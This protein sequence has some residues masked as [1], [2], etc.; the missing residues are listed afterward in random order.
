MHKC[1]NCGE[2]TIS[3]LSKLMLGPGRTIQCKSCNSRVSVSWW[4]SVIFIIFL[5]GIYSMKS[6]L[7]IQLTMVLGT[8]LMVLYLLIHLFFI[9]L[10][11]RK[12]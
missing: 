1:P 11:V 12:Y 3:N 10:E 6:I 8:L 7:D 2:E 9:P 4:S 5:I